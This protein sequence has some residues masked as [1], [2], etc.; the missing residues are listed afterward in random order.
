M[1]YHPHKLLIIM[2]IPGSGKSTWTRNMFYGRIPIVSSDNIRI[3]MNYG[4]GSAWNF[5]GQ[6]PWVREQNGEVFKRFHED[7]KRYLA[8]GSVVADATSL[9]KMARKSLLRFQKGSRF[10]RQWPM[11]HRKLK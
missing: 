9:E 4:P 11:L 5:K 2:G 3:E 1:N 10:F 6:T 7:I 8:Y